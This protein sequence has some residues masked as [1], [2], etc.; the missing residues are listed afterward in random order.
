MNGLGTHYLSQGRYAEAEPLYLATLET[1]RRVLGADH[2]ET[3]S[4]MNGLGTHYLSQGRYAEAEP[5]YL[6]TLETSKRVLGDHHPDTLRLGYNLACLEARRGDRGKA[7]GRLRQSVDAGYAEAEWMA[8]DTDLAILHG[9]EF[10]A[11]VER[12]R[13]NAV[14]QRA[15]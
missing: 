4:S 14:D 15:K 10:D 12:A 11:L 3:L 8:K 7:L 13:R 9:P 6:A 2:H 1:R 5:L